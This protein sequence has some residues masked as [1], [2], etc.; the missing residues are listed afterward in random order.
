MKHGRL[1]PADRFAKGR[2]VACDEPIA[3]PAGRPG[4]PPV[5]HDDPECKR[6]Y[7]ALHHSR[8][9]ELIALGLAAE[10]RGFT[11]P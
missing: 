10:A 6:T 3:K 7:M 8:V 9:R 2:C 5:V 4:S 11:S 1:W